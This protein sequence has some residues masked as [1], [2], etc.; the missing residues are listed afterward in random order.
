MEDGDKEK[1]SLKNLMSC[2]NNIN[3]ELDYSKLSSGGKIYRDDAVD[4][5][6]HVIARKQ[7]HVD[8]VRYRWMN[9]SYYLRKERLERDRRGMKRI[10]KITK[11]KPPNYRELLRKRNQKQKKCNDLIARFVFT[12]LRQSCCFASLSLISCYFIPNYHLK[13][14]SAREVSFTQSHNWMKCFEDVFAVICL[15]NIRCGSMSVERVV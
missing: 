2:M 10:C 5:L 8:K 6:M 1:E 3:L 12:E 7:M 15:G 4:K 14:K 9:Q 13:A 11:K